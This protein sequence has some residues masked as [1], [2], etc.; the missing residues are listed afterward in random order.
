MPRVPPARRA[1]RQRIEAA[2]MA[3]RRIAI[4]SPNGFDGSL[5]V[6]AGKLN[7]FDEGRG[8]SGLKKNEDGFCNPSSP[9]R[10][11]GTVPGDDGRAGGLGHY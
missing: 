5:G 6:S 9:G 4:S 11:I 1:H 2:K 7:V 3:N 8:V 10:S